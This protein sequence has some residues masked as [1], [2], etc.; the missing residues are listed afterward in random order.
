MGK[1]VFPECLRSV[2]PVRRRTTNFLGIGLEYAP[3]VV[4]YAI[5]FEWCIRTAG[6]PYANAIAHEAAKR[7]AKF[8]KNVGYA[9]A[10]VSIEDDED[11]E[12]MA[13]APVKPPP[14]PTPQMNSTQ[15]AEA[16]HAAERAVPNPLLPDFWAVL[17]LAIVVI[18]NALVWFVQRWSLRVRVKVQYSETDSLESGTLAYV[19]PHPH[20]GAAD[21]V[22]VQVVKVGKETQRF[23][24]FQRQKFEIDESGMEVKE[25][26]MPIGKP[27]QH[28]K[29]HLGYQS[30]EEIATSK[31]R[32]GS[33]SLH[34]ELPSFKDAFFKQILGPVPVFQFFCASLWLLDEYWNYA[35]FQLFSICM[36]ESSTVFGKIK[37]MQALRGMKKTV[38]TVKVYRERK[39]LDL[40][41]EEL[42]PGDILSLA[43]GAEDVTVPCDALILRGSVVVNEAALTGESTPQ[44]KEALLAEGAAANEQLDVEKSHRVHMLYGGTTMMQHNSPSSS[45]HPNE[46]VAPDGGCICYCV[47]TGFSSSEGKLVRMIEYSQ[48][49]VLTDAKEVLA[50]LALLLVFALIA[51]G[52][53][54]HKGLKEGKRS[55]YEL[56]LRCVLILTSVVPPELPMQTAVAVNAAVFALF[57]SSVFCTEPFRIPFAGKVEYCLFD[58]TGTLTTDKLVCVG[59]WYSSM[60]AQED[61]LPPARTE[62]EAAVVLAGCHAL[63]QVGDK[64]MGDPVEMAAINAIGWQYDPRTQTSVPTEKSHSV[65]AG[66]VAV[67]VMHRYHFASK[68]QRMSVLATVKDRARPS[69]S[70]L[71]LVKGSPEIIATLLVKKPAD[72]DRAYRAMAE[73]GMRVLALASRDLSAAEASQAK[74]AQATGHGPAREDIERDLNFVGFVAFACQVRRDTAEVVKHL[75]QSSHHVA[76]AT[77]DGALT[78][79]YV[80]EEVGMTS[81]IKEKELLLEKDDSGQLVWSVARGDLHIPS[82]A[83]QAKEVPRLVKE[84]YDLCVT[85]SSLQLAADRDSY[86]WQVVKHIKI[87]ARMSPEDKEAVLRALKE[88]GYH[89]LMCGDGANDV[90]ALKQAHIG[91]AL[92][93]GFGAANTAKEGEKTTD[94]ETAEEK[95]SRLSEEFKKM[96]EKQKKLQAEAK[97]DA[98]YMKQWQMQRYNE[99]VNEYSQRGDAWAAF[100]AIKQ[101]AVEARDELNRR[102]QERQKSIGGTNNF[103][104]Q[105]ALMLSD[106]DTGEVPQIK[107]GDASVAA[108]FTSKLPSIKS[109]VDIIRQGRCTLVSTIQMQQV[110]A[111]ECLITAYSMSALYLDGV[112]KGENQLL[113]TGLLLMVASLAFSYSRPVDKL[114]PCRPITTI[115]H[116]AIWVSIVGQ[117]AIH[118]ASMMYIISL[119]RSQVSAEEAAILDGDMPDVPV[120]AA[121]PVDAESTGLTIKFKPSLLNTVVFLVQTAQQAS[122][123]A[124]NYKGRPFMLAAT[125]NAAMGMSLAAVC[126][127]IFV[128]AFEVFPALNDLLK[129][130][131]MPSDWFRQQVLISLG[132]SVFGSLIWDRL[133]VAVFAPKLLWVGY[134]DAWQAMPPWREQMKSTSKYLFFAAVL[135]VYWYL[136]Q[137]LIVLLGAWYLYRQIFVA[138]IPPEQTTEATATGPGQGA[139]AAGAAGSG[140]E[141]ARASGEDKH[142]R[143]R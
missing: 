123:M 71:A 99:L 35:L 30:A 132:A 128:C 12:I 83:F 96:Q 89:T 69:P 97:K 87:F 73:R 75:L 62:R 85:G 70:T 59:T 29:Q 137:S 6:V 109:T 139:T 134:V 88:Q 42:L 14:E 53:V 36:Y 112:T 86:M 113:A 8:T 44:M 66:D 63:V 81:G 25:L 55:Q 68:L 142:R 79:L 106:M 77:G 103:T 48:E 24:M 47:R 3:F 34:I 5:A 2:V 136:D 64:V 11:E 4:L 22:P 140:Q 91:V 95:K 122:V 7:A 49:Q 98:E 104:A 118:L 107:L 84:G 28:Y 39:W 82:M 17:F 80:G 23:F 78:A 72:Y 130:V 94:K 58:K 108:P 46:L 121:K 115:F 120:V 125:E 111:L 43:R 56:I 33:N 10:E 20:Q 15:I 38:T 93:S 45:S 32:Y 90:G 27:L 54:L 101:A 40:N 60:R 126:T 117:L 57:R 50:L 1:I 100:K 129:L 114:S 133:C 67:Q 61:P 135:F 26:S 16:L 41:I 52:H 18:L 127:G 9:M 19:T 74:Q 116:P 124:V 138:P 21:V 51:S 13:E 92:L 131:P 65:K 105:A 141:D 37:N 110:L 31:Q 76:M 102:A 119:T 143:R